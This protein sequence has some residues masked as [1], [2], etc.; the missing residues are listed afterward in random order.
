MKFKKCFSRA[1]VLLLCSLFAVIPFI[2]CQKIGIENAYF[3]YEI[4]PKG[5]NLGFFDKT[6]G[7]DYLYSDTVSYCAYVIRDGK[8]EHV[9]SV[10]L[11]DNL[12]SLDFGD[13][14]VTAKIQI[15]SANDHVILRVVDV[16]GSVESLTFL[17]VP[18]KLE[19][20]PEEP[21][22][23]CALSLNLFTHVRQLPALQNNLWATCYQRFGMKNAEVAVLGVPQ[24]EILPT[25]R[26]VIEGA[27]E[28]PFSDQGG[29]WARTG[30]EGYGSYL[31]NFG[32]LT[33]ET[34]DEWIETC[35][36]LGFTQ[37]DNHGGGNFFE[38]GTFELNKQKWPDGWESFKRINRRLHDAGISSIFHSYAFFIDKR[39]T[40][41]TPVPS[42]DLGYAGTFTLARPLD[43]TATEVVVKESTANISTVTGFHTEN[44]VTLRVGDELMTF[45]GVTR[46]PPYTFT[47]LGRGANGTR[48]SAHDAGETAFHLSERFGRFVPGPD[49]EL[50][51]EMARRH[52]EIVNDCEFDGIYLDAIDGSTVLAGEDNFRYYGTKFIFEIAKHLKRPVGM[53]MSS[54]AHLWWHYRSRY[55][56]WDYPIRGYKRFL[57]IHLASIKNPSYFLPEQIKS[58]EWGHGLWR[59][60][61][62]LIDK[63]A[64]AGSSQTMLPLHLGW[65]SNRT[66]S[67]PQVEP[68]FFD[69]IEYLGCKMIGNNAGFSQTG[70]VD[71]KTLQAVPLLK[72]SAEILKQYE[73]LRR[74]DYFSDSVRALLR[75]AGKE[76]TLFRDESGSWNFK[77]AVYEKQK[78]SGLNHPSASWVVNNP[79]DAQPVKLR[80]EPLL[81]VKSYNDPSAV[82]LADF[83][84]PG[85]F[86]QEA[87]ADGVSGVIKPSPEK[88]PGGESSGQFSAINAGAVPSEGSYVNM[89]KTFAPGLDLA[90]N[91]A[92]GAW[93][94]GDGSGQLLNLSLRSPT[95]ISHGAHGDHFIKVDFTG[96]RYFE[97]VEIESSR[98]SDYIWPEDSLFYVYNSHRHTIR[99]ENINKLQLWYNNLPGKKEV[100]CLLGPVKALPTVPLT[101]EN[102][103]ITLNGEKL[104]IPVKMESGMYLELLSPT[105]C[106]LYGSKGELLQEVALKSELPSLIPGNN[107]ISFSCTGPEDVNTRVQVTVITH[108][109]P[110]DMQ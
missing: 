28:I 65:W 46:E 82:L 17:N 57:D 1:S 5:K 10:S 75:Q 44:S 39:S 93:V 94:K 89:E 58:N 48:P 66:W 97:L 21:F 25:I 26:K 29:A 67:P 83:S 54:M 72:R 77:P 33:E 18:L 60:H 43:E 12:L 99:F 24:Q 76:Y 51:I 61:A 96:W 110:L 63:Y 20:M 9:R 101:I 78:V 106:K 84:S 16:T 59:G 92:L 4:S 23:A 55:Q 98:I 102:P 49:T 90:N 73:E 34:V 19:A 70:G 87:S 81:A 52:A 13:S 68:T 14:G 50:F 95:H 88:T 100:S 62:P 64:S 42:K 80:I 79:F 38:F 36:R 109:K 104:V 22:A 71:E 41:V 107:E 47:G 7:I 35:K 45:S 53:E 8:R 27:K 69:D 32:T 15:E 31:M 56:A 11:N 37:V 6:N 103:G 40:Y 108:G 105:D 30:K 2:S 3:T 85:N 86:N 74:A 91:Q